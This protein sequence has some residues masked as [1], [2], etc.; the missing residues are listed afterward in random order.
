MII[1]GAKE[2]SVFK[3][4]R[5]TVI[6]YKRTADSYL[7]NIRRNM[8]RQLVD[9]RL[10]APMNKL[11]NIYGKII[12][13]FI[14]GTYTDVSQFTS[15]YSKFESACKEY[16]K[17]IEGKIHDKPFATICNEIEML[18]LCLMKLKYIAENYCVQEDNE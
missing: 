11:F 9:F 10:Y 7:I 6:D 17:A 2:P 3:I 13:G 12:S 14:D 8:T 18:S 15:D 4:N 1:I 16:T 5:D